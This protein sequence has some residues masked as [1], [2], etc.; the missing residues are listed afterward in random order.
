MT[1]WDKIRNYFYKKELA[2]RLRTLNVTRAITN[3][4]DAKSIGL[5]Y[6]S[7]DPANDSVIAKFAS[8]LRKQSKSVDI[9]GFI[10]DKKLNYKA[11]I[12]A[13]NKKN[14]TWAL[15][16]EG[17]EVE[18]FSEKKY[19]LLL[20]CFVGEN[21]PLEFI[22]RVSNAKWRVGFYDASKTDCYD[23]MINMGE[24]KELPYLLE[25]SVYF[26]NQIKAA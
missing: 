16:P 3:L 9:L 12:A 11:G 4:N 2:E 7:T 20:A 24:H 15:V 10:N 5:I 22:A 23:M 1:L 21:L 19:D 8:D 17:G 26:L 25:Q 14:L 6:D 18:T 13:F